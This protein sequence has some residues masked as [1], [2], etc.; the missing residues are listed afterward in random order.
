M[1][2][3]ILVYCNEAICAEGFAFLSRRDVNY[4]AE[5]LDSRAFAGFDD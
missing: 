4:V 3:S 2:T 1:S 5:D